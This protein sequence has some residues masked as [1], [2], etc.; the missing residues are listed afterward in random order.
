MVPLRLRRPESQAEGKLVLPELQGSLEAQRRGRASCCWRWRCWWQWRTPHEGAQPAGG[1]ADGTRSID[2]L[3]GFECL[4][5]ACGH[6]HH[7]LAG[8]RASAQVTRVLQ[9]MIFG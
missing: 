9:T 5:V 6:E 3:D 2:V 7:A 1:D 8:R 4:V